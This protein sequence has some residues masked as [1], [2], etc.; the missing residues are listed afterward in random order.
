MKYT[1]LNNGSWCVSEPFKAKS[2]Y[3]SVHNLIQPQD[4][5]SIKPK[6]F[7]NTF[8]FVIQNIKMFTEGSRFIKVNKLYSFIKDIF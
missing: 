6:C 1:N 2:Q 7:M 5:L 3:S 4:N 8:H